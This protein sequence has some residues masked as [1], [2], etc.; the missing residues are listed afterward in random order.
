ME[1]EIMKCK[2]ISRNPKH[3]KVCDSQLFV[4]MKPLSLTYKVRKSF[5]R[6]ADLP[7]PFHTTDLLHQPRRT[8]TPTAKL[9]AL[10]SV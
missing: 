4:F 5:I 7:H 10:R 1:V 2:S 3:T 8:L 6:A 9:P